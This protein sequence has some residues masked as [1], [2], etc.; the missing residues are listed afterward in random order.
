MDLFYSIY[1]KE[2][3]SSKVG[4]IILV[5]LILSVIFDLL[6]KVSY[7]LALGVGNWVHFSI[8]LLIGCHFQLELVKRRGHFMGRH[9]QLESVEQK[10]R[11]ERRRGHFIG[12]HFQLVLVEE[13]RSLPS[14]SSPTNHKIN[15]SNALL[16]VVIAK[17]KT[18]NQKILFPLS[19]ESLPKRELF[20][21]QED[22]LLKNYPFCKWRH[23]E[24]SF[25]IDSLF[26][27]VDFLIYN[28]H[29]FG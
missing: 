22:K 16:K 15:E 10:R 12:C 1:F 21:S 6:T 8:V 4:A 7:G 13:E 9:F 23:P 3:Q 2:K 18:K 19:V 24:H 11:E 26:I 20:K 27:P 5:L 29:V 25:E 28:R 14:Q 17:R